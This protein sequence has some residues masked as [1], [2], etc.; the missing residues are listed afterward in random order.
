MF[1]IIFTSFLIINS[2]FWG[3]Y[4]PSPESPHT[5]VLKFIGI[6]YIP[7]FWEHLFIGV[8]FYILAI[9]IHHNFKFQYSSKNQSLNI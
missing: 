7:T 8:I 9:S 3:V 2:I 1:K 5:N 6:D 4:P